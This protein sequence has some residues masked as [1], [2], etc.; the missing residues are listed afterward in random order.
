ME[1]KNPRQGMSVTGMFRVKLGEEK[2][3]KVTVVG[4]SGW[5]KNEVTNLGF[6]N[7]IVG[8]I[9]NL[10]ASK[11]VGAMIIGT[12][13]APGAAHTTLDGETKRQSC[14]NAAVASKTLR[15]TLSIA[16]GAHPT[17][18]PTIQNIALIETTASDGTI[19]CGNTYATSVWNTN[20]GLSAT[21]DL[22]FAT[23]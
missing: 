15:C 11:Y 1:E 4:D 21:Y 14:G 9:G 19:L 16:S 17:G 13:T 22:T 5:K 2:D 3:G 8:R 23:A 7:Y 18:T 20:Q 12:G 10:A 6:Q